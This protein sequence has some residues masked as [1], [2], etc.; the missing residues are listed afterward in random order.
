MYLSFF[1]FFLFFFFFVCVRYFIIPFILTRFL[2]NNNLN[3]C[4]IFYAFMDIINLTRNFI[5]GTSENSPEPEQKTDEWRQNEWNKWED[6]LE[7]EWGIFDEN[8]EDETDELIKICENEW[9]TWFEGIKNK[10]THF[11]ENL[12]DQYKIEVLGE[13]LKWNESSWKFWIKTDGREIIQKDLNNWIASKESYL[14]EWVSN[15]WVKWKS[16]KLQEWF[17]SKW[18]LEENEYWEKWEKK[19]NNLKNQTQEVKSKDY[20][21]WLDWK[22]RTKQEFDQWHE[23][24][25]F[26]D[27][28]YINHYWKKWKKWKNNKR[29]LFY[30]WVD[31]YVHKWIRDNKWMV[32][33]KEI[34][35]L[36]ETGDS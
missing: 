21:K 30:G 31:S 6:K 11:S 22:N 32:L 29:N 26:K 35:E 3:F 20:D 9:D 25:E 12:D 15:Q 4:N 36:T 14:Y 16:A 24:A 19:F 1:F 10:W 23:W 8:L 17:N 2:R 28:I 18:K 34:K 33:V 27:N 7:E 13:S 5:V